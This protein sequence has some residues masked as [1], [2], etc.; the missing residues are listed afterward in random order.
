MN[1]WLQLGVMG[2]DEDAEPLYLEWHRIDGER[3]EL[4]IEVSGKPAKAGIDPRV[5]FIDREPDD[6]VKDVELRE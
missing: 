5:L 3:T 1:D 4:S 6:N 2:E